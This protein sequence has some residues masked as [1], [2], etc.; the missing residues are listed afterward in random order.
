LKKTILTLAV[1]ERE[2]GFVNLHGELRG[3]SG[4]A[5]FIGFR[6]HWNSGGFNFYPLD[7]YLFTNLPL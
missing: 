2:D 1:R 7:T 3:A 5:S 6:R 4:T